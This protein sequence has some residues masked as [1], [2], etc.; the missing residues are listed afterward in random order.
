[1]ESGVGLNTHSSLP[2]WD[3]LKNAST[4]VENR[5]GIN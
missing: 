4:V 3:L 2:N 5:M 1:M